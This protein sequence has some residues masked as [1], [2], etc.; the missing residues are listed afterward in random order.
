MVQTETLNELNSDLEK[1]L[2]EEQQK[3]D[4]LRKQKLELDEQLKLKQ[5]QFKEDSK[6]VE[7]NEKEIA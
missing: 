6:Q 1:K 4:K 7:A 5:L 3:S 2:G